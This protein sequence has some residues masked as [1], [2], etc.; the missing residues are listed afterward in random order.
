M[1]PLQRFT[2][3]NMPPCRQGNAFSLNTK[4]QNWAKRKKEKAKENT[5]SVLLA[6]G[7]RVKAQGSSKLGLQGTGKQQAVSVLMARRLS[8]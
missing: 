6:C 1:L 8:W 7:G 4:T 3:A 2:E 5:Y